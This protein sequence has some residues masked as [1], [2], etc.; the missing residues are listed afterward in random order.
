MRSNEFE[1]TILTLFDDIKHT[2][3]YKLQNDEI[4]HVFEKKD[5]GVTIDSQLTFNIHISKKTQ[6]ANSLV[7]LVRRSFSYLDASS[8][9]KI[10]CTFIRPHLEYA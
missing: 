2:H 6:L 4:D 10:F 9:K 8:F 3:R 1:Q 7:G 5:L